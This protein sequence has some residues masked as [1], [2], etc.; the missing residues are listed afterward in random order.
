RKRSPSATRGNGD[1][2]DGGERPIRD[3]DLVLC[4]WATISDP[5]QIAGEVV[6]VTGGAGDEVL[7]AIKRPVQQGGR[8]VLRSDNPAHA[9]QRIDPTWTLR[10]V[11]CVLEVVRERTDPVLWGTY[12]RDAIA[13]LFGKKNDP[14][15]RTGHRDVEVAG[16]PHTILMVNLHKEDSIKVEHRYADRFLSPSEFQWESQATTKVQSAKGQRIL[17]HAREDRRIHLF[18]RYHARADG[19]SERYTYC[20]TLQTERHENE[21]PIRVWFR[22]EDPLPRGLWQAW[23]DLH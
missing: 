13:G 9:D 20:G 6:L 12:D 17:H 3:G 11:A 21:A 10:V 19:K 2:M 4:E 16:E 8:W 5:Q 7:A 18:V 23:S 1:P 15:W 22:L 14:S